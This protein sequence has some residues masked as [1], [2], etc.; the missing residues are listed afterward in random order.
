[1]DRNT[2]LK[3]LRLLGEPQKREILT[4]YTRLAR[5]FPIQQFPER[6]KRLLQ[7]KEVLLSPEYGF[8]EVLFEQKVCVDWCQ[9][10]TQAVPEADQMVMHSLAALVRPLLQSE[11]SPRTPWTIFKEMAHQPMPEEW[12]R[13]IEMIESEE[14]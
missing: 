1:M 4:A 11:A 7:A 3:T 6:H 5:R 9:L 2:A 13:L 8:Q 12:A 14:R 10:P